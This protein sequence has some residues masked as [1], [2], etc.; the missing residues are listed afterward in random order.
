MR[1]FLGIFG[2]FLLTQ[3]GGVAQ[4][5]EALMREQWVGRDEMVSPAERA[6]RLRAGRF[7]GINTA[8]SMSGL[9]AQT[10]NRQDL[11][12]FAGD[13]VLPQIANGGSFETLFLIS[14]NTNVPVSI[15]IYFLNDAGGALMLPIY[16]PNTLQRSG[17]FPGLSGT[18][19]ALGTTVGSTY[20]SGEPLNGGYAVVQTTPPIRSA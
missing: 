19:S 5:V 16:D 6:G 2:F 11:T 9:K 4:T 10:E 12:L 7:A 17:P 18:V 1:A 13:V 8:I 15:N 20:G 14:N 3:T